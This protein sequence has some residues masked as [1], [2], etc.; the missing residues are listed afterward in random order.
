M[1]AAVSDS[2]PLATTA[3]KG[4]VLETLRALRDRLASE[5]D[6]CDSSR[7]VA[8]LSQRLMDVLAQI[9]AAEKARPVAKGTVR[10][11]IAK[12][13]SER[14]AASKAPRRTSRS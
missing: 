11:D 14:A 7:D 10:D 13:R 4:D 9:D 2:E 3:A 8:A 1:G 12:R 5:L 6:G